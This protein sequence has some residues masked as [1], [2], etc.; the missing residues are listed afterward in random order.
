MI[1]DTY[2]KIDRA[3][4]SEFIAQQKAVKLTGKALVVGKESHLEIQWLSELGF[5]R[6]EYLKSFEA[7]KEYEGP[8]PIY[9]HVASNW[10]DLPFKDRPAMFDE[11]LRKTAS[12]GSISFI[13]RHIADEDPYRL[14]KID[15]PED[16]ELMD[17]PENCRRTG[18]P[19][20][21]STPL[22]KAEDNDQIVWVM[23]LLPNLKR[24][25]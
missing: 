8:D 6:I 19:S 5:D 21:S 2:N 17:I 13:T 10:Q 25:H 20:T 22:V 15:D 11:I 3:K 4:I 9:I 1:I 14:I 24:P 18:I 23:T 16:Q 7:F 12:G